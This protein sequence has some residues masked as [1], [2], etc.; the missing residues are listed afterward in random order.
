MFGVLVCRADEEHY[1]FITDHLT[2]MSIKND[3]LCIETFKNEGIDITTGGAK[4]ITTGEYKVKLEN[5][6]KEAR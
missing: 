3:Y 6:D 1:I 5:D 4:Y 2:R